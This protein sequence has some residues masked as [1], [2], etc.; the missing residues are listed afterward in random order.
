MAIP[1][2]RTREKGHIHIDAAQC[3]G[4]GK[5]VEVCKDFGLELVE[6]HAQSAPPG[7]KAHASQTAKAKE[8]SL[9]G[10]YACGHCMAACP[11][12]AITI[13]GRT[14][15]P[16]DLFQLPTLQHKASYEQLLNLLQHRRSI[17][18]FVDKKVEPEVIDKILTAATTSPMG[19]PPSDVHVLVFDS[20]EKN[21]KFAEDYCAFLQGKRWL[22]SK[23]FLAVMRPFLGRETTELFRLFDRPLLEAY[24]GHMEQGINVITYDA[25]LMLYFYGTPYVDPADPIVAATTAMYA[26]ESLG[27]GTCMLGAIHPFIQSGG[28]AKKFREKYGI[29]HTSREGLFVIFGYPSVKYREGLKRTFASVKY[30]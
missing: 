12:E 2:S 17:R 22:V 15:S 5:C 1:T 4:C 27:L 13:H 19:I 8:T 26:A 9:F 7:P 18:E 25:P 14:L 6:V 28:G 24:I 3:N 30:N 10:C 20:K 11:Q 29:R 16:S 21:R 23:W